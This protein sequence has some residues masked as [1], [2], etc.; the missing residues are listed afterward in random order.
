MGAGAERL[1]AAQRTMLVCAAAICI[2]SSG[3]LVKASQVGGVILYSKF[4]VT[5]HTLLNKL[6]D[7]DQA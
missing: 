7:P 2:A 5:V 3:L 4:S 1:P 6:L